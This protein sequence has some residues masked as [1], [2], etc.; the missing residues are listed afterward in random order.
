MK[1]VLLGPPGSGKGT[2]SSRIAKEFEI[3]HISTGDLL[4]EEVKKGT[5]LGERAKEYMNRGELVPNEIVLEILKQRLQQPDCERGFILDGFPRNLEQAKILGTIATI[6]LVIYLD[7]PDEIII[8]RL[9]NRRICRE[10]G[11]I[12]NLKS[13]P[14]KVPGK[15]DVCGSELYQRDD[16][17]PETIKNRLEVYREQTKPLIDHYKEKGILAEFKIEKEIPVEE[18]VESIKKLIQEKLN[19]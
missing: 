5:E 14:P 16:D 15:C 12:Y 8:E 19:K 9:S 6:D 13:M 3:P 4:R 1:L 18:G 10:C 2:Y 11:A 17:K 7:V